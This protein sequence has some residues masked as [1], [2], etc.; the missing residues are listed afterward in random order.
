LTPVTSM[1]GLG[2]ANGEVREEFSDQVGLAL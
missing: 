1:G 2:M